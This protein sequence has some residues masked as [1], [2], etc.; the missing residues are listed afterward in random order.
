MFIYFEFFFVW[1]LFF[2]VYIEFYFWLIV[3]YFF[4]LIIESDNKI[5]IICDVMIILLLGSKMVMLC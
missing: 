1:V 3:I 5:L 4:L 2:V